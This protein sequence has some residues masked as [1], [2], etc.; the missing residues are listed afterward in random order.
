MLYCGSIHYYAFTKGYLP[1]NRWAIAFSGR[2]TNPVAWSSEIFGAGDYGYWK[3]VLFH[4]ANLAPGDRFLKV[5]LTGETQIG[6]VE[7]VHAL[8][9]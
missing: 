1:S 4:A 5:E 6:R 7:I 3:P 8:K 9:P 2:Y